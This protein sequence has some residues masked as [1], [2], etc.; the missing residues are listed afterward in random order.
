MPIE[1]PAAI[2][3][4]FVETAQERGIPATTVLHGLLM[5]AA[6]YAGTGQ[7]DLVPPRS[8]T[9]STTVPQET[10]KVPMSAADSDEIRK[11]LGDAGSSIRAV[12]GVLMQ[13][14]TEAHGHSTMMIWP[15]RERRL[16]A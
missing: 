2:V 7:Y 9:P 1:L 13:A 8:L 6:N 14:Y 4:P 10:I 16:A 11:A 15:R 5:R 3:R 12:A